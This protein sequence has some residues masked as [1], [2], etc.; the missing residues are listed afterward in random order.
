V[1]TGHDAISM[2]FK[3]SLV[4]ILLSACGACAGP[5]PVQRETQSGSQETE[6]R[7][8][9]AIVMAIDPRGDL[10][11][12]VTA[13]CDLDADGV[14]DFVVLTDAG[15]PRSTV[16]AYSV[17]RGEVL[18]SARAVDSANSRVKWE[19]VCAL[20]DVTSD[21]ASEIVVAAHEYEGT[22]WIAYGEWIECRDGRTGAQIW[23][24]RPEDVTIGLPL[25]ELGGTYGGSY[26]RPSLSAVGDV[27]GD[28]A[29]DFAMVGLNR[30]AAHSVAGAW[31]IYSGSTGRR[32]HGE[33]GPRPEELL[34]RLE[35]CQDLDG[36]GV[37]DLFTSS[38]E[39][40]QLRSG[41]DG[42]VLRKLKLDGWARDVGEAPDL[43]GDGVPEI[44]V[45][46][47]RTNMLKE[48]RMRW[49]FVSSR[50][51]KVARRT[52][53]GA[54]GGYQDLQLVRDSLTGQSL[55]WTLTS[56][57]IQGR[58]LD[59]ERALAS[60]ELGQILQGELVGTGDVDGDGQADLLV[61]LSL[62]SSPLFDEG[63]ALGPVLMGADLERRLAEIGGAGI[64]FG[65]QGVLLAI[66]L[67]SGLG[68]R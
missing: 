44:A 15:S 19:T 1:A 66:G 56:S 54:S 65:G 53:W 51:G 4:S 34:D 48:E 7:T 26:D 11:Y 42:H 52:R 50:T 27:D 22:S 10:F 35:S 36:D 25:L 39:Y 13:A 57:G 62:A 18:W 63:H 23:R 68:D 24:R 14:S 30:N 9:P 20:G 5:V 60:L 37:R 8:A 28:G 17:P 40:D 43:D 33:E 45:K 46:S 3:A 41:K 64:K 58:T 49:S 2:R 16:T 59:S 31:G 67:P 12:N 47:T 21:G 55:M 38:E 61:V 6:R 29:T 32:L